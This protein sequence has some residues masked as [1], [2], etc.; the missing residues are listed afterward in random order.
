VIGR[1]IVVTGLAGSGKST[2]S[3]A[4]GART[5]LPV[6]HLDLHFWRKRHVEP[7]HERR[8]IAQRGNEVASHVLRSRHEVSEFLDRV[9]GDGG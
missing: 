1:R 2:F 3:L 4:L 8:V 9:H 6:I 5:G 7:D